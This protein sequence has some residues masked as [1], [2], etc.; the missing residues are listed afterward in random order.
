MPDGDT[1]GDNQSRRDYFLKQ[2]SA[3]APGGQAQASLIHAAGL[4][5]IAASI[6]AIVQAGRP[7][8]ARIAALEEPEIFN[9]LRD[10]TPPKLDVNTSWGVARCQKVIDRGTRQCGQPASTGRH[11][12]GI[13]REWI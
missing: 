9:A 5:A 6:D 13:H 1:C 12:C 4:F 8:Q 10:I 2:A 3:R 7:Q 11:F